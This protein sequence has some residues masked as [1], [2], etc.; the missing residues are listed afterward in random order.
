MQEQQEI[1]AT[2]R[3]RGNRR[4]KVQTQEFAN[5]TTELLAGRGGPEVQWDEMRIGVKV[6]EPETY[7]G[8][9]GRDL[10][11]WLF[12]V[13]EHLNITSIPKRGHVPYAASLLHGNAALWWHETC[14][15]NCRP[16]NWDEFCRVLCKRFRPENYSHH[17]RD[18]LAEIRQYNRKTIADFVFHFCTMCLK[19]ADLA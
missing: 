3:L 4:S 17:G 15:A 19:I 6:E 12:Q 7:S 5:L 18:K 8:K 9:K 2:K 16:T 1:A 14:E 10:D 11:T 13:R